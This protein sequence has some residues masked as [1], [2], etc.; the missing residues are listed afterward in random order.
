M[1][2]KFEDQLCSLEQAKKL[3]ELGVKQESHFYWAGIKSDYKIFWCMDGI[4]DTGV[5]EKYSAFGS[6]ELLI[7]L[8]PSIKII[9][10]ESIRE[11]DLVFRKY[12]KYLSI[13]EFYSASYE[14][15]VLDCFDNI[16]RK[17]LIEKENIC[18]AK[19][20]SDLIIEAL[21]NK[22]IIIDEINAS[23]K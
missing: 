4:F 10:Y 1:L 18:P 20:L 16:D 13:K 7:M 23:F 22:L 5:E 9:E 19:V 15:T 11:Y 12:L 6:A 21:E 14:D 2:I 17:I 3:K 8:P